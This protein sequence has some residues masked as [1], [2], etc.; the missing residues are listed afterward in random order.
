MGLGACRA[1]QSPVIKVTDGIVQIQKRWA[2][3]SGTLLADDASRPA[4]TT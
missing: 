2:H 1:A 3:R 4:E